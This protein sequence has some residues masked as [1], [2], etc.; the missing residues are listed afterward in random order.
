METVRIFQHHELI[1]LFLDWFNSA[2]RRLVH[3]AIYGELSEAD[4]QVV[5][6]AH[7]LTDEINY[8]YE[9]LTYAELSKFN[10]TPVRNLEHLVEMVDNNKE[11]Y[12]KFEF[13]EHP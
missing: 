6:L 5:I 7:V 8:G 3:R 12:F 13:A 2:P 9:S 11:E 4:Q 10:G 1:Q